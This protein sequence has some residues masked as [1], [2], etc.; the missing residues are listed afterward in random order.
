M[1][2]GCLRTPVVILLPFALLLGIGACHTAGKA[3]Q[4]AENTP[5]RDGA[6][7]DKC[8][9]ARAWRASHADAKLTYEDISKY[10]VECSHTVFGIPPDRCDAAHTWVYEHYG[11]AMSYDEL[12][13]F[14]VECRRFIYGTQPKS[15]QRAMW[16]TQLE[17]YKAAHPSLSEEQRAVL[18]R[19]IAFFSS[20]RFGAPPGSPEWAAMEAEMREQEQQAIRVFGEDEVRTLFAQLGPADAEGMHRMFGAPKP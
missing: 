4:S 12:L 13:A 15:A 18:D 2:I 16:T 10:P 9:P 17:R 5:P 19:A 14:P 11:A 20:E 3:P 7:P 6:S 8:G 1:Q